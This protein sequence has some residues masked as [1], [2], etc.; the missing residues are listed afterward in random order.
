MTNTLYLLLVDDN[1]DDRLL[2]ERVLRREFADLHI[3]QISD[4][5]QFEAALT[6]GSF[7]LVITDYQLRWST[8]LDVLRAVKERYPDIPVVMF[9]ATGSE[10][11]AVE[12]MKA[13]LDD[14]VLKSPKHFRRLSAAVRSTLEKAQHRRAAIEAETR[15]RRLFENVPVGLYRSTPEGALLDLNPAG[16]RILGLSPEDSLA[17]IRVPELYVNPEDRRRF[18]EC[19]VREGTVQGFEVQLRR[20]DGEVIW[21]SIDA[22]GVREPSGR[23]AYYEGAFADITERKRAQEALRRRAEETAA[24]LETALALTSLDLETTLRTIGERAKALFKADGCRIALLEPDGETLRFVLALHERAEAVLNLRLKLGEGITGDVALRGE[25]E[26]VN[27]G[28]NDPR[29]VQVPGTPVEQEAIM[30]VPLK[31]RG[32]VIGVMSVSRL[33]NER[34]FRPEDLEL[35][36]G[37]A[38]M[39]STAISEAKLFEELQ[40]AHHELALAYEATIEGWARALELRD[41]E[42]EGHSRRVVEM[43]LE[44]ARRMGMSA[45]E[46]V[47]VRRG[48]L[49]HDIGK[50]GVPDTILLKPGPLTSEEWEIMK[51]HPQMAYDLLS[52]I[53]FLRPALD[54]PYCHHEWWDGSG[55]PRGLK[56][57]EIP[58]AARI[59]AVVD[60][61]DALCSDRPYRQAWPEEKARE[62]IREQAGKLFDPQ[63][64][65]VFFQF[66]EERDA[67]WDATNRC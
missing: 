38:S 5:A 1:P 15:Y 40:E 67:Q 19:I 53:P 41:I 56:G 37:L 64:V 58:L 61:Y 44:L 17:E 27:D 55:Y 48:A 29:A 33:G 50:M 3:I 12:A 32:K 26:I 35:L 52:S 2:I 16:R 34:P 39:A 28:L 20:R 36:K 23:L 51:R 14:Y 45:E 22:R 63:V 25:P 46:L 8:G 54:I 60:V 49:L 18:Q 59:F 47:H 66:L 7:D 6:K 62:Y 30:L 31:D 10:E 9:T 21:V 57:E 24:L 4:R 11:I 65:E 43:T 13:G 42:T